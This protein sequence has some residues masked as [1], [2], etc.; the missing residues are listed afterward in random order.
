MPYVKISDRT[1]GSLVDHPAP[2]K[3]NVAFPK[4]P[5][6]KN[7]WSWSKIQ[8]VKKMDV[9]AIHITLNRRFYFVQSI[10]PI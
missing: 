6:T 9:G 5:N 7:K 4:I 2:L 3:E 10:C 8:S 1:D